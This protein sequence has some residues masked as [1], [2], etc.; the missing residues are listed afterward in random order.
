[1]APEADGSV[2]YGFDNGESNDVTV[3]A[4]Q[5]VDVMLV[6]RQSVGLILV[7]ALK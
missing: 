4:V 1:M 5:L 7:N 6:K 2:Q 3:L